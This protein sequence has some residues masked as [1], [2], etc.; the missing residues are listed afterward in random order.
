V[1][2]HRFSWKR[3]SMSGVLGYAPD[4][5]ETWLFFAMRSGSY[6]EDSLIEFL[7]ELREE[8]HSEQCTLIWDG[9]PSHKSKKMMAFLAT[10]ADWLVVERLPGYAH[11]LNPIEKVWGNLKSSELANLC[12]DTIDEAAQHAEAGLN[13]IGTDTALCLAFLKHTGLSL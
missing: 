7:T 1:L 10:Q 11:D 9:L 6:N 12:P 4:A 13:R 2:V 5:S 8:L 3:M